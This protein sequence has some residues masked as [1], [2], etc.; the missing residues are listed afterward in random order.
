MSNSFRVSTRKIKTANY[1]SF[2][3]F[4]IWV[5]LFLNFREIEPSVSY[6]QFLIKKIRVLKESLE[7]QLQADSLQEDAAKMVL[8]KSKYRKSSIKP[9]SL[10]SPPFQAKVTKK[11]KPHPHH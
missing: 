9:P 11:Q 6:K 10:I 8:E 7:R 4:L 3:A 1:N 2:L 5:G